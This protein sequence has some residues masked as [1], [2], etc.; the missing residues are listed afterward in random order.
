VRRTI[1]AARRSDVP[2]RVADKMGIKK[3]DV[4][5]VD[6][7]PTDALEAIDLPAVTV[8]ES[9]NGTFDHILYFVITQAA[10]AARFAQLKQH[11]GPAGKLWVMW[12]KK[13]TL[14]TDLDLKHVINIG[15]D[16]GLVES[17]NLRIDDTWTSL[18][19]TRPK[20]GKIY[21]NSYGKL[22]E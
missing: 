1:V 22:T 21:I 13:G 5:F 4:L 9:L 12:P 7:A 11:L 2:N 16:H 8:S 6:E 3:G 18:K 15:Y 10:M 17:T 14:T 19:F 20:P